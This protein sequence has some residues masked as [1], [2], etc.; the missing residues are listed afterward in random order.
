MQWK[1]VGNIINYQ[2]VELV[3]SFA[4]ISNDNKSI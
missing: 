4:G 2:M 3:S 1:C